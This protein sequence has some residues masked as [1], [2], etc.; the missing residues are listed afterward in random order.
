MGDMNQT[1]GVEDFCRHLGTTEE[2]LP[3]ECK[4]LIGDYDFT[5]SELSKEESDDIIL[6][7]IRRLNGELE[8]SSQHRQQ[9]WEDG[10]SEN[11][12]EFIEADYDLNKVV[13]KFVKLNE[14][15]RY[16]GDYVQP[17]SAEFE[18]QFV[19]VL[20]TYIIRHLFASVDNVYEY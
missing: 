12:N 5:Y 18:T 15:I 6:R 3:C 13:P 19:S 10:W 20:S 1:I 8:V 7:V 2:Q 14:L 11:L 4:Q 9:R 17:N 16:A